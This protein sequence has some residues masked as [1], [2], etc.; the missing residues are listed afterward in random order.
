[1][2]KHYYTDE[3]LD[4]LLKKSI[5]MDLIDSMSLVDDE[6]MNVSV[7]H[8]VWES[9]SSDVEYIDFDSLY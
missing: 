3:A 5:A 4:H 7:S 6:T 8:S 2:A 9:N 1:M